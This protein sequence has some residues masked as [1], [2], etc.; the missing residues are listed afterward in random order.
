MIRADDDLREALWRRFL[1]SRR[2]RWRNELAEAYL[3]LVELL[4]DEV[5]ARVPRSVDPDDLIS[6]GVFGLLQ[7][8]DAYDPGRNVKFETFCK[9]RVRGA[10]LDELRSADRLSRDARER[11][12]S[13]VDARSRLRQELG[14][15]PTHHELAQDVA[16]APVAVERILAV[17]ATRIV[18]S[19]DMMAGDE[20]NDSSLL[21]DDLVDPLGEP[22]ER[23][24]REDLLRL[25]DDSLT[26]TERQLVRLRYGD[27]LTMRKIGRRL[28]VSESR[29]CQLH[30]QLLLRLHRRLAADS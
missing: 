9:V 23:V 29:V 1:R 19:L 25:I 12:R 17:A 8:I 3:P 10:M 4:A 28:G 18:L 13:V 20:E 21:A 11:A 2:T 15:E 30:T 14:R 24:Q 7:S 6:V 16:L 22:H 27:G 26:A 5:A